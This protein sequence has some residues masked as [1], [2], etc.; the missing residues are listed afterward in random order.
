MQFTAHPAIYTHTYSSTHDAEEQTSGEEE[1][2]WGEELGVERL[3]SPALL[4]V[5]GGCAVLPQT[6]KTPGPAQVNE[7]KERGNQKR[8][9][10]PEARRPNPCE[11]AAQRQT[12]TR[13][14]HK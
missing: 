5:P 2:G 13:R 11:R 7:Q 8:K 9:D 3:A 14:G 4:G 6:P 1:D 12:Y 10:R